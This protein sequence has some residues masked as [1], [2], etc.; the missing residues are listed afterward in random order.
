MLSPALLRALRCVPSHVD[1]RAHLARHGSLSSVGAALLLKTGAEFPLGYNRREAA[2]LSPVERKKLFCELKGYLLAL[3]PLL[4][5]DV[6][7]RER[8]VKFLTV[9]ED[10]VVHGEAVVEAAI[11]VKV[12][13]L[14]DRVRGTLLTNI[15]EGSAVA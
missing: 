5:N 7:P 11:D 10:D 13:H 15:R 1:V 8:P 4:G 6:E 3:A 14:L 2:P 12:D 9:R